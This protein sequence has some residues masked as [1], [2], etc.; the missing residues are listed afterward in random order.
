M[1]LQISDSGDDF[2]FVSIGKLAGTAVKKIIQPQ[3][4]FHELPS[5]VALV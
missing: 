1:I 2:N 5:T 3:P 4:A